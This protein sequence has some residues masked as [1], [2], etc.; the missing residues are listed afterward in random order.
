[1]DEIG[2]MRFVE[3]YYAERDEMHDLSHI[4]RFLRAARSISRRHHADDE[5]LTYAAYFHGIDEGKHKDALIKFMASQGLPNNKA[6]KILRAASESRKSSVPKIIEGKVL[7]D[8][9][10]VVGGRT[11][12]VANLLVT[13]ALRGYPIG[14]TI[15]YFEDNVDGKFKC[16]LPENQ[17]KYLKMERFAHEFFRS[18][19]ENLT[20]EDNRP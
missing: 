11:F 12:L 3:P 15:S 20:T 17:E 10:L 6:L 16:Y 9:H 5:V 18:L 13:G 1:M 2:L 4:R 14:H 8:A 7:H 19:R